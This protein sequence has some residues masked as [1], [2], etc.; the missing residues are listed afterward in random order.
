MAA[1][2]IL[3]T[4]YFSRAWVPSSDLKAAEAARDKAEKEAA[5]RQRDYANLVGHLDAARSAHAEACAK[6]EEM[7]KT[8]AALNH[9][10]AS[11]VRERDAAT[12]DRAAAVAEAASAADRAALQLEARYAANRKLLDELNAARALNK[13]LADRVAVQ[14]ELLSKRAE[15]PEIKPGDVVRLKS[16]GPWMTVKR[17][18]EEGDAWCVHWLPSVMIQTDFFT[19][20]TLE[21]Q[22]PGK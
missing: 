15:S 1:V 16:G 8:L 18:D 2:E 11:L 13:S 22:V 9:T 10:V 12:K 21:K 3:Y 20:A 17:I 19:P 5:A 7:G 14:S 4:D 6:N